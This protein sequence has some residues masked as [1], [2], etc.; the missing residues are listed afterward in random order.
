MIL[1]EGED[2]HNKKFPHKQTMT[3]SN[4]NIRQAAAAAIRQLDAIV[5]PTL[6]IPPIEM[7]CEWRKHMPLVRQNAVSKPS[8]PPQKTHRTMNIMPSSLITANCL[9]GCSKRNR[10]KALPLPQIPD[11]IK[12]KKWKNQ[13][14]KLSSEDDSICICLLCDKRGKYTTIQQHCKQ[15]F[16]PEYSCNGCGDSWHIKTQWQEHFTYK[17]PQCKTTIKGEQNFKKHLKNH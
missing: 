4:S 9:T 10:T 5:F 6:P 2:Q 8:P 1:V 3:L 11:H 13:T 16:L 15:H 17:C 7:R 12:N 14:W